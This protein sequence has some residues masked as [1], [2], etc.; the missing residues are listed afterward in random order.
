M[1][2][3]A[4]CVALSGKGVLLLGE[5]GSGKSDLAL[6]LIDGGA[7]LV[8]DDQVCMESRGGWLIASPPPKLAGMIEAR[9]IGILTLPY[10]SEA[11]L[12]LAVKLLPRAEVERLPESAFFDCLDLRIPLVCLHAFD[13]SAPARLRLLM[14]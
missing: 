10:E 9:G 2:I 4:T 12:A 13:A 7:K 5:P 3:H 1:M 11:R 14:S 8:A 6:R